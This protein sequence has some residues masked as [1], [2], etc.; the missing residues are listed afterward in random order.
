MQNCPGASYELQSCLDYKTGSWATPESA[1]CKSKRETCENCVGGDCTGAGPAPAPPTP[2]APPAPPTPPSPP[3]PKKCDW[4]TA[5][6]SCKS[7]AQCQTWADDN[8]GKGKLTHFCKA[9][10]SCHFQP[11]AVAQDTAE[12]AWRSP[13]EVAVA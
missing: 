11:A 3:S 13:A 7:D 9:N 2:P 10:G 8:C 6:V 12:D 5:N 4:E 1:D